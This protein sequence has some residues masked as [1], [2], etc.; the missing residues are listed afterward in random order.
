MTFEWLNKFVKDT[1]KAA[2]YAEK[3]LA[4]YKLGMKAK[5]SIR[6]VQIVSD[7][8]GCDACHKLDSS[9]IY[10]PDRA[11]HIP[12]PDCDRKRSCG[13]VYRPVMTYQLKEDP[14][15]SS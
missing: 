15:D 6:G 10:M 11:P 9:A 3:T 5:G 12:L 4:A 13:C 14:P 2:D 1:K 8:D 7:P